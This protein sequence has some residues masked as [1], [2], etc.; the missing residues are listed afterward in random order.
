MNKNMKK[1][2]L[3]RCKTVIIYSIFSLFIGVN[4]IIVTAHAHAAQIDVLSALTSTPAIVTDT[5]TPAPTDT[6]TPPPTD[7]PV[8]PTPTPVPPTPTD[9]PA[10]QPTAKPTQKPVSTAIPT[11]PV[12]NPPPANG[13]GI[14]PATTPTPKAKATAKATATPTTPA[15]VTP[16]PTT[17][18]NTASSSNQGK[19]EGSGIG[20]TI[21]PVAIGSVLLLLIGGLTCFMFLRKPN[22]QQLAYARVPLRSAAQPSWLNQKGPNATFAAPRAE[23]QAAFAASIPNVLPTGPAIPMP[24]SSNRATTPTP[25]PSFASGPQQAIAMPT[26]PQQALLPTTPPA[27]VSG[28]QQAIT[29]SAASENKTYT[30]SNLKPITTSLPKQISGPMQNNP[31]STSDMSP[32]PLD[33]FDLSRI[34]PQDKE[35][36]NSNWPAPVRADS[37]LAFS[38]LIAPNIQ[39]DPVLETIMRQAQ[40]GLYALS[41]PET[42]DKEDTNEDSFLS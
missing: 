7:T 29:Q 30:P 22:S 35:G 18:A 11:M 32:L 17:V 21:I 13:G 12:Q 1:K 19:Q 34:L 40:M 4:A 14:F 6:P 15:E 24:A 16:T 5:P 26:G 37:P 41:N 39:D 10:P 42:T 2:V 9:T 25:P 28:P 36:L 31:I 23:Q 27:F 20:T 33:N 38:P 8:P 3:V